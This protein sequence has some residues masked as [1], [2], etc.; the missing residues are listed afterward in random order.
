[1]KSANIDGQNL[2]YFT[3]FKHILKEYLKLHSIINIDILICMNKYED[4]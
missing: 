3:Y 4:H 2:Q 1:M